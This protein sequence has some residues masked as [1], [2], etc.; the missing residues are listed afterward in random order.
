MWEWKRE[1]KQMNRIAGISD[2]SK[3]TTS[4]IYLGNV[5]LKALRKASRLG[6]GRF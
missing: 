2:D 6:I 3:K 5:I 4:A 1:G